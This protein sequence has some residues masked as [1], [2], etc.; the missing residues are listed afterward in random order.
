M[1]FSLMQID[2]KSVSRAAVKSPWP[3]MTIVLWQ[4]L[5]LPLIFGTVH[6]FAP[7]SGTWSEIVFLTA[8]AGTIFGAPAFAQLINLDSGLTLLGVIAS[9]LVMP[10]SLPL[11]ALWILDSTGEFDFAAYT[12]RLFTFLVCPTL[13]AIGYHR[14]ARSDVR[15]SNQVLQLGSVFFLSLFAVAVMDG[16]GERLI[17]DTKPILTLLALAF[18]IHVTFFFSTAL[19]FRYVNRSI[20]WTAGL[21]SSY[22]NLGLLLAVAG[23]L[24]PNDF[25]LFVALWQVPM[26]IM[27]MLVH[28]SFRVVGG[29]GCPP[30][31]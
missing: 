25:I 23:S 14:F 8:C 3:V 7:F 13:V 27:P 5:A 16:V 26:Y 17:M 28:K 20:A 19:I 4:M 6:V 11:L 30:E 24:L 9:T 31:S 10:F 2:L 18:G 1:L 22:R 29:Y 12:L 21:L 15:L